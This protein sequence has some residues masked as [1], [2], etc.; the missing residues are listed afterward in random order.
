[1]RDQARWE[2]VERNVG[3]CVALKRE[4]DAA[5]PALSLVMVLMR[6]NL[7]ELPAVVERAARWGIGE[8][9]AQNLSH[10]FSD[11]PQEAYEAIADY[12]QTQTVVDLP[13]D[14]VESVF[15][16]ARH[17]AAVEGVTLR[18]PEVEE[19]RG[20]VA[21]DGTPVGCD[22]PWRGAYVSYTGT[23]LPCC[24]VMGTDRIMLGN[25][26]TRPFVDI[27][28]SEEFSRFR[29]GLTN[30]NPHAVCRGCSMYR[31]MF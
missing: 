30:G 22:W 10:D 5:R 8:V 16:R 28:H 29:Q 7:H 9:F 19:G 15:A 18:L 20:T 4:R 13:H 11:A 6:H 3:G 17:V 21:V 27:W 24:M 1:M 2:T 14:E 12:V 26:N 23:V 25:V 31:G